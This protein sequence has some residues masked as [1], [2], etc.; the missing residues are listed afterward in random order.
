M[1]DRDENCPR[2]IGTPVCRSRSEPE[3]LEYNYYT[4]GDPTG[5]VG[6]VFTACDLP[7][8]ANFGQRRSLVDGEAEGCE[9]P[10]KLPLLDDNVS[11][12]KE[13]SQ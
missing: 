1:I 2:D 7:C 3:L 5:T 10:G 11:S 13:C 6:P 8:S 9:Y 12:K 4:A